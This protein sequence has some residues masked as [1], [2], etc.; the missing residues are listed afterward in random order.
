MNDPTAQGEQ[1]ISPETQNQPV[2]QAAPEVSV[3][4]QKR[5]DELTAKIYQG[6]ASQEALQRQ[7]Q[8]LMTMLAQRAPVEQAPQVE[9]PD[10]LKAQMDGYLAPRLQNLQQSNQQLNAEL[11]QLRFQ[12]LMGNIPAP[13]AHAAQATMQHWQSS[14]KRGW[15][16]ED[17]VTFAIGEAVRKGTYVPPPTDGRAQFNQNSAPLGYQGAQPPVAAPVAA[18]LPQNFD[19][20]S[21]SAKS[22]YWL[23]KSGDQPL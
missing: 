3:G 10:E 2:A 23:E 14:G 13:I 20:W 15:V 22:N 8:E 19:S 5:F 21:E 9:I 4:I 11:N 1:N 18:A 6:Q 7:N 17:A 12:N 16:P